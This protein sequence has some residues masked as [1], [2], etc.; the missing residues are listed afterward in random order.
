MSIYQKVNQT[1]IVKTLFCIHFPEGCLSLIQV[2]CSSFPCIL[3][4]Y[5]VFMWTVNVK[6]AQSELNESGRHART[7][8]GTPPRRQ[9]RDLLKF[10]Y[11]CLR[12]SI[13]IVAFVS[14]WLTFNHIINKVTLLAFFIMSTLDSVLLLA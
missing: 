12:G 4:L 1:K 6:A 11:R 13:L 5:N 2:A 8:E 9:S 14:F 7:N 10:I 3:S